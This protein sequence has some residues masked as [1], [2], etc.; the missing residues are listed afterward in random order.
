MGIQLH[1]QH[2]T[3]AFGTQSV[4]RGIDLTIQPGEFISIVGKSGSGKSTLL[5]LIAGLETP[6]SGSIRIDNQPL[7]GHNAHVRVMF[8]DARLLPWRRVIDNVALGLPKE[9]KDRA[10]DVLK[11]VGLA[12][13]VNAWPSVLS[14]GERQRVALARALVTHPP[15]L[16]LDEPLGALDALTRIEMQQLLETIW[17]R[18]NF[19]ALLITHDVDEAVALGD[20][21]L[22]IEDGYFGL[23]VPVD[24]PRSRDRGSAQ[25]AALKG[26]ILNRVLGR[27]VED[28]LSA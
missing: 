13:K 24:L 14:G 5:R 19:S 22:L 18:E 9:G 7:K 15:L 23:D 17:Q 20:R 25:F 16:L 26:H 27:T 6:D 1:T 3:K 2:L 11:L 10:A 12:H 4:L 8:Q 28:A 21:V